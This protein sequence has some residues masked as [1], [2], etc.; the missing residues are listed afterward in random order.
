MSY[1]VDSYR[2]HM[3]RWVVD[4]DVANRPLTLDEAK[5][6]MADLKREIDRADRNDN[7]PGGV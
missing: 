5:A 1:L 6:L 4:V 7:D 3:G 2:T